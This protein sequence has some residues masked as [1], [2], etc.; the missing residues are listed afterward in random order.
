[1]L[2]IFSWPE[3]C[4]EKVIN[5]TANIS[6]KTLRTTDLEEVKGWYNVPK[7]STVHNLSAEEFSKKSRLS[8]IRSWTWEEEVRLS[9]Q[10][11]LNVVFQDELSLT[12]VHR[13]TISRLKKR[14][15]KNKNTKFT[16]NFFMFICLLLTIECSIQNK[17][18]SNVYILS[19]LATWA[20][21]INLMTAMPVSGYNFSFY[22]CT[23]IAMH[24]THIYWHPNR[25]IPHLHS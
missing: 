3:T 17:Y 24:Y 21:T 1:M 6:I 4:R 12:R 10:R 2:H 13:Q 22:F 25:W 7:P 20:Y 23:Q 11:D 9:C 15:F 19:W 8:W 16:I 5:G 14:R 18:W